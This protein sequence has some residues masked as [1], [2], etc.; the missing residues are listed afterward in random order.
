V[1]TELLF[2]RVGKSRVFKAAER[3]YNKYY[4]LR[5]AVKMGQ[6]DAAVTS[7]EDLLNNV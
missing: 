4:Y 5:A 6:V 3:L 2:K 7:L 1:K